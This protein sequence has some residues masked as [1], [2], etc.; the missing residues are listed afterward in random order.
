MKIRKD[1]VTNSSSSSFILAFDEEELIDLELEESAYG[2]YLDELKQECKEKRYSKDEAIKYFRED[3][4][5]D[6]LWQLEHQVMRKRHM[7][8]VEVYKFEKTDEFQKMLEDEVNKRCE[9][10]VK[11][12]EGKEVIVIVEHGSGGNGEDG[13]LECH[14]LPN[15]SYCISQISHH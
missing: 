1:F 4:Y 9:E 7:N 2:E 15:S 11:A 3:V 6:V 10:F 5:D 8:Y 13:E 12:L 14:I